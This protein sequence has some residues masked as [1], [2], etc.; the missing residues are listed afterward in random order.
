MPLGLTASEAS[1]SQIQDGP[2]A[3]G[4][5]P[6]FP[7]P[8][9]IAQMANAFFHLAPNQSVTPTADPGVPVL[10]PS[11]AMVPAPNVV[12][13]VA[14][15]TPANPLVG[16]PDLPPTTIPSIVPTP[17]LV[18]PQAPSLSALPPGYG[19]PPLPRRL[20]WIRRPAGDRPMTRRPGLA[21][22]RNSCLPPIATIRSTPPG[23]PP[24]RTAPIS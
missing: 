12:T 19:E 14:P 5:A 6:G 20:G 15:H 13:S 7:D 23:R 24:A 22:R 17:N 16:P 2:V 11:P 21:R 9:I 1:P 10:P 8:S 4:A 3:P 18:A